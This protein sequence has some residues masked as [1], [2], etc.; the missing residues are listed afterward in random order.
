MIFSTPLSRSST[1]SA[2]K[3]SRS[4]LMPFLTMPISNRDP[5]LDGWL[6]IILT[7]PRAW[8]RTHTKH[9]CAEKLHT[10][11]RRIVF[12]FGDTSLIVWFCGW[13]KLP[14]GKGNQDF[15]LDGR[16]VQFGQRGKDMPSWV[17]CNILSIQAL[18]CLHTHIY[19]VASFNFYF[20]GHSFEFGCI[21]GW[22][23]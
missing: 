1:S 5:P 6:Y 16:A 3:S 7:P 21:F 17:F 14:A 23:L 13:D 8:P 11:G 20:F 22:H 19:C 2:T 4:I 12:L 15:S 10:S 9:D 18:N